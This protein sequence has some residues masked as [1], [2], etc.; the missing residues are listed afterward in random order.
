MDI[1]SDRIPVRDWA[2][3]RPHDYSIREKT[4][5]SFLSFSNPTGRL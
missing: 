5:L 3:A 2:A 4:I 1:C